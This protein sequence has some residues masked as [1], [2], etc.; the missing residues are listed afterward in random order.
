MLE[1]KFDP[2]T[3]S[4]AQR[5]DLASFIL[6]WDSDEEYANLGTAVTSNGETL[7]ITSSTSGTIEPGA[8]LTGMVNGVITESPKSAPL[9]AGVDPSRTA[10][11]DTKVPISG[12][13]GSLPPVPQPGLPA[14]TAAP[15]SPNPVEV[16]SKG[17]PWDE[18]IHSSSKA[19]VAG[20]TWKYKRGVS[21]EEVKRVEVELRADNL[22]AAVLFTAPDGSAVIR[23]GTFV[24]PTGSAPPPP[25]ATAEPDLRKEFAQLMIRVAN[26]KGSGKITTEEVTAALAAHGVPSLP[27][28]STKLDQVPAVAAAID[29]LIASRG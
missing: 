14:K 4:K 3:L 8:I 13:F 20:G 15:Q 16:D 6:G 1:I 25:P 19:K 23:G 24:I 28:L 12:V 5:E 22:D 29:A 11:V 21:D 10:P 18:R 9:S 2:S 17:M 26:A 27:M 7:Q